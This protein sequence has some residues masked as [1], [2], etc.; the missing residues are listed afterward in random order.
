MKIELEQAVVCELISAADCYCVDCF[1][2]MKEYG[3]TS[4]DRRREC[5]KCVTEKA[6]KAARVAVKTWEH[7][8]EE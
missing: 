4:A 5:R 8:K 1:N 6:K 7:L 3:R 2:K